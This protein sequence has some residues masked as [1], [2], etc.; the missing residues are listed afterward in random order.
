MS[1]WLKTRRAK[2]KRE[3]KAHTAENLK[4]LKND[5]AYSFVS[6]RKHSKRHCVSL[7]QGFTVLES[8]CDGEEHHEEARIYSPIFV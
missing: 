2:L 8:M 5:E 4:G 1:T 3:G 6:P 7:V